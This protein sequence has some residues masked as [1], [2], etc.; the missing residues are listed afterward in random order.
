LRICEFAAA[1]GGDS[2]LELPYSL[3]NGGVRADALYFLHQAELLRFGESCFSDK[4]QA[5][6]AFYLRILLRV[7]AIQ[8]L[9]GKKRGFC[10]IVAQ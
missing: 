6:T 7:F 4:N 5:E 2:F 8:S 1:R 10:G 9:M 3:E